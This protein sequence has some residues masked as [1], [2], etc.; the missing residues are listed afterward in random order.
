MAIES[1]MPSGS[2]IMID[3]NYIGGTWVDWNYNDGR[4]KR[5]DN[6]Y[7]MTGKG[8]NIYHYVLSGSSD[9]N[10]IGEHYNSHYNIKIIIQKK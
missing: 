9:W 4:V 8:A 6:T 1:K 7:P 10:L 2:I 3:D 5:I